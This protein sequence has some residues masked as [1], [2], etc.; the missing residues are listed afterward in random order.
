MLQPTL[1]VCYEHNVKSSNIKIHLS[2]NTTLFSHTSLQ[3]RDK[4]SQLQSCSVLLTKIWSFLFFFLGMTFLLCSYYTKLRQWVQYTT[5]F[6]HHSYVFRQPP[7]SQ[8]QAVHRIIK[9]IHTIKPTNAL[10]LKLYFYTQFVITPTC[11]GLYLS[12]SGSYWTSL[13]PM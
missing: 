8:H 7:S 5:H 10:T 12:S 11:F 9:I 1:H 2:S 4:P 13:K 6:A 3:L